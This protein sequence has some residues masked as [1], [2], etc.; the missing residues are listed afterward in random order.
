VAY[1]TTGDGPPLLFES[2]WVTHL[3]AQPELFAFGAFIERLAER[4]TVIRFDK[5]GCGLSDRQVTDFSFEDQVAAALAV[6]DVAGAGELSLFGAS[7]GG[8]I[9]AAIAAR[10]PERV[11]QLVV[12]GMCASGAD[13]APA[14]LR[15]SIV[16]LVK[17]NWGVGSKL[18]T[19]IFIDN[20]SSEDVGALT[21][22]QRASAS[23]ATASGL[24][25][26]YYQTDIRSL[27]PQVRA[28]TTVLHRE[29]DTAT[30]FELGR[31][32]AG[33]IPDA[34]L[35]PLPGAGHLFYHGEWRPGLEALLA[36]LTDPATAPT[37][38]T[39][40]ELEVAALVAD[41]LTNRAIASRLS[42]AARTAETHVE[43]IR[44]KLG[45]R[46]RAQIAAWVAGNARR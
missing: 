13:L 15:E 40:R 30:K 23:A 41:G 46:S 22:F 21:T 38:L 39:S 25:G 44:R 11:R 31:E 4:F 26:V 28:R 2:G 1:S 16:A 14:E 42:V 5:A 36:T 20:P 3:R 7:Q 34:E 24:L 6:A 18:M 8:Q 12:Y 37:V 10:Y 9:V 43:N 45:V 27:L 29:A 32:V 19:G 33:L 35:I 17:A